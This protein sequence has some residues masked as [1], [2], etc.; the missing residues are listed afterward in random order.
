MTIP[1]ALDG[2]VMTR[3]IDE[4]TRARV[5]D[6]RELRDLIFP[7]KVFP[8]LK[9]PSSTQ[10]NYQRVLKTQ[11]QDMQLLSNPNY[12]AEFIQGLQPGLASPYWQNFTTTPDAF[13]DRQNSFMDFLQRRESYRVANQLLGPESMTNPPAPRIPPQ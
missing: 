6:Y 10:Q 9:P 5:A 13:K 8:G 11:P 7:D 12:L 1:L 3:I 4:T 2:E